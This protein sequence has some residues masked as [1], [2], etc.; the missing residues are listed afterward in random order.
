MNNQV[1]W[2]EVPFE[3]M[4]K[5]DGDIKCECWLLSNSINRYGVDLNQPMAL[6]DF[7]R[8]IGTHLT[9][10]NCSSLF[11]QAKWYVIDD[12]VQPDFY[13]A[14]STPPVPTI[15][16]GDKVHHIK[17]YAHTKDG[18]GVVQKMVS[19]DECLVTFFCSNR[20]VP[21]NELEVVE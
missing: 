9:S 14:K 16:P 15:K 13:L 1:K 7:L 11:E 3:I 17:Y 10:M 20:I 8:L 18:I 4:L 5:C 2:R 19:D 6:R 12:G 21:L